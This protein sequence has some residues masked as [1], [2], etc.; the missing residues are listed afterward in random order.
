MDR[1]EAT[2]ERL[3]DDLASAHRD[4]AALHVDLARAEERAKAIEAVA[5]GDVEAAKRGRRHGHAYRQAGLG[6]IGARV[7][8]SRPCPS[9]LNPR[10]S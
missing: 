8:A 2:V 5:R 6:D 9:A 3:R 10:Q 4:A 1:L 7:H